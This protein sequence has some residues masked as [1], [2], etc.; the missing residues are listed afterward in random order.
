MVGYDLEIT[1]A[2]PVVDLDEREP[3]LGV[4]SC[5]NP[6]HHQNLWQLLTALQEFSYFD[7]FFLSHFMSI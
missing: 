2:R 5:A 4:P 6:A 1:Q 3:A 7:A